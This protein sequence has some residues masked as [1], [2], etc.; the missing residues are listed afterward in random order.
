MQDIFIIDGA[1][2]IVHVTREFQNQDYNC[3]VYDNLFSGL[4]CNTF[5][6]ASFIHEGFYRQKIR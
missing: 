3:A 6:K 1:G 5:K 2:C 4:K